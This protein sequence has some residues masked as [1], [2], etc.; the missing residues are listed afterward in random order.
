MK[1]ALIAPPWQIYNRPSIQIA[2]LKAFLK[3]QRPEYQIKN[4]HPYIFIA[5]STD[6][7][8]YNRISQSGWASEAVCAALLFPEKKTTAIKLIGSALF[9]KKQGKT[10]KFEA[11]RILETTQ[12]SIAEY[13]KKLPLNDLKLV[14][15]TACLNQLTAGLYIAS[16]IKESAPELPIVMGGSS[17]AEESGWSILNY[18][19]FIDYVINGEGELPLLSLCDFL[20]G[21]RKNFNAAVM[22]RNLEKRS[23]TPYVKLQIK[24]INQLPTPD[25][26]DYFRELTLLPSSE[27]IQPSL[28]VEASRGCWWGKCNFCNLNIQWDKY[29][30]KKP[31]KIS[32]EILN[33]SSRY[34]CLDFSF[35]DN[36]LP[37]KTASTIFQTLAD[38]RNDYS[39]FTEL[40]A[41]HSRKEIAEMARGG[42]K[43]LQVGVESLSTSLLKRLNKGSRVIDNI[44]SIR[45]AAEAGINLQAN[46]IM[47]FPGSTEEEA[48]ETYDNLDYLWPFTPLKPVNFWL[49]VGSPVSLEPD[50]YNISCLKPASDYKKIF[51]LEFLKNYSPMILS[52]R[53]DLQKQKKIWCDVRK[54]LKFWSEKQRRLGFFGK[55]L[56]TYREGDDFLLIKQVIP[57]G[58]TLYHKLSGVSRTLYLACR[59]ITN[60][61]TLFKEQTAIEEK[62]IYDFFYILAA[63]RLVFIEG[64]FVI[65]LA[66]HRP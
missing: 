18:F 27:K 53:G 19:P 36:T 45:H 66:V 31:D 62:K 24:D 28:S 60:F 52:Y 47:Q 46:L 61:K 57:N 22:H 26:D 21:R 63:K 48:K 2:A 11:E 1:I 4:F 12:K 6:F 64:E 34:K 29:R 14:G 8:T 7:E 58:T 50:L 51:T 13:I 10:N 39:F 5:S 17:C 40:R 30:S 55:N 65:S 44:A 9:K 35:M 37:K 16:I 38:H 59:D 32:K 42:L 33:L 43:E 23:S 20:F 3:E 25:Y 54:K 15:I 41:V 56:L 49:G